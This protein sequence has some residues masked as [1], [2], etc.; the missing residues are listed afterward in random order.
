M[1]DNREE[2]RVMPSLFVVWGVLFALVS[3]Y[4]VFIFIHVYPDSRAQII[5]SIVSF[6]I[7]ALAY[8]IFAFVIGGLPTILLIMCFV[9]G[10]FSVVTIDAVGVRRSL[11]GKFCKREMTWEE[12][13]EIRFFPRVTPYILFTNKDLSNE[14]LF[15]KNVIAHKNIIAVEMRKKVIDAIERFTDKE[16]VGMPKD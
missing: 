2:V 7:Y 16:I 1:K 15:P 10:L 8:Y 13:V 4:G 5:S 12:V 3:G 9:Q 11:F 14:N 6:D